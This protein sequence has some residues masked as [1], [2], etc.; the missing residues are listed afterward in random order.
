MPLAE[1]LAAMVSMRGSPPPGYR[2]NCIED[3]VVRRGTVFTSRDIDDRDALLDS[4][5]PIRFARKQCFYNSQLAACANS[6]LVYVEGY[7]LRFIPILHAWLSYRGAVVDL[8]LRTGKRGRGRLG[9]RIWGRF[10]DSEYIGVAFPD[11]SMLRTRMVTSGYASSLLDDYTND[12]PAM[13]GEYDGTEAVQ[14]RGH[15]DD[16]DGG[17]GRGPGVGEADGAGLR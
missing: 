5:P 4:L 9:D 14:V 15:T 1:A 12:W 8:T 17:G 3:F 11:T 16:D 2:Y 10:T 7:V 13:R 6:E